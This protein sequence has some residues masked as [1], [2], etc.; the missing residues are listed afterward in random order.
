MDYLL[1]FEDYYT[2]LPVEKIPV[3][4]VKILFYYNI[5]NLLNHI[6]AFRVFYPDGFPQILLLNEHNSTS[7]YGL[8][9]KAVKEYLV[10]RSF[11]VSELFCSSD[12]LE[13]FRQRPRK[14][15]IENY[16]LED[17]KVRIIW[18]NF[19]LKKETIIL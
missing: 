7:L 17:E 12:L 14:K 19:L 13:K 3:H 6:K 9:R 16:I 1:F 11:P 15:I 18:E 4:S 5:W 8:F 10:T 2:N